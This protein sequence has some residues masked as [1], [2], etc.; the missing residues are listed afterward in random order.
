MKK[1]SL[2]LFSLFCVV[3]LTVNAQDDSTGVV[4]NSCETPY[5]CDGTAEL[6]NASWPADCADG[7]DEVFE[8]CCDNGF[9]AYVDA[10]L[11]GDSGDDSSDSTVV[12]DP[13]PCDGDLLTINMVDSYGDGGG[14]VT[15]GDVTAT[16]SGASSATEVCVDMSAC[17]VV[18]Y[19]ATDSWSYENSW[20]ISDA[21]G[22][23]LASGGAED[24][25]VGNCVSG[26][27]D[28]TAENYNAD[29]DI[30]DD[31]LCEYAL[32][33]G[34]MDETACNYDSAAEQD[35]GSCTYAAEGL[36][37]DG[38]CLSGDL[39]TMTDSWGDG[40]NG[41]VLTI[42]GVDYTIES[43]AS[44]TA[45]VDLTA[46][47]SVAWTAGS[48]DGETSWTLADLSGAGGSG[49]GVFGDCGVAGCTDAT[50]CNYNADASTDDGSCELPVPGFDCD[51]N[52]LSGDVVTINMFDSYGDGGGSVSVGGV[53]ATNAGV[54]SVTPA[55][56]DMSACNVVDYEATDSWSY[57]NSWSIT[58][59]LG[60]VLA[61]GLD[62]DGV[63]GTCESGCSDSTAVNFNADADLVDD[64]L[65][66]YPATC[67]YASSLSGSD[68]S[69]TGGNA[70]FSF[71]MAAA[72]SASITVDAVTDFPE[73]IE[74]TVY[75]DCE[76]SV[77]SADALDAGTYFVN[78]VQTVPEIG[79]VDF[80]ISVD[81]IILGCTDAGAANYNALA[82][83]DDESCT[84]IYGC[85]DVIAENYNP[86]ATND[87]GS[88][89][90]IP[91]CTDDEAINFNPA[92]T[93]EDGSCQYVQC[94]QTAALLTINSGSYGSEVSFAI[95]DLN[96][97]Y[98]A[99]I[100]Y[101]TLVSNTTYEIDLCLSDAN[102]Y[103]A[104][105]GDS[106]G[107][108]WN[109]GNFVITTCDGALVA[110]LGTIVPGE[111]EATIEFTVQDCD[112]YTFG[113]TDSLASN[114]DS[115]AD[116]EDGSCLY[117]GCTDS[118]YL[119]YDEGANDDDGSCLTL[120]VAGCTDSSAPN[121]DEAANVDDGSC[122]VPV[123]CADSL[124]DVVGFEISLA[125]SYGD[126]WNG[127][128]YSIV[129][130]SG[131]EVATGGMESGSEATYTH[132]VAPGCY[133]I[134]V[135]GGSW[136]T[137]TSWSIST[138]YNGASLVFGGGDN[139]VSTFSL[140]SDADCSEL[141]GCMDM[142]AENYSDMAVV[143]D[144]SCTYPTSESCEDA[145]AME[146]SASG[147][148]GQQ[149]WYSVSF[150]SVQFVTA[151][152][153][154]AISSFYS[155]LSLYASCGDT[156]L[157][158]GV[159]EAGTY[160]IYANSTYS[161]DFGEPF[162]LTVNSSDVVAGC[163]DIYAD[164]YNA[165]ANI[166]GEECLY[167]CEGTSATMI[168]DANTYGSEIYWE[169]IDSTGLIIAYA[170]EYVTGDVVEIPLC[171]EQNHN[172][173]MNAYD[174]Y[175]DGWNGST[176]S[177]SSE[178]GEDS[179]AFS[180]V[181]ANNG[182]E[183]PSNGVFDGSLADGYNLE[184]TE[185][186][187]LVSCDEVSP[188]CTD[189]TAFNYDSLANVTDGSCIP[190]IYG[191]TDETALNYDADAN[192]NVPEDCV[193]GCDGE[194]VTVNVTTGLYANEVSWQLLDADGAQLLTSD[195][196]APLANNTSYDHDIC[197]PIGA[198]FTF[199]AVDSYGDGWNG[200]SFNITSCPSVIEG[201]VSQASGQ[202][203]GTGADYVFT[204]TACSAIVPGCTN[205]N[206]LNYD[207][208]ATH[209]DGGC[210][211][212]V[213]SMLEPVDGAVV[214]L[215]S[216]DSLNPLTFTW[217]P[218][219]PA[220]LVGYGYYFIYF[221]T[222]S[223]DLE[224]SLA[225]S[226]SAATDSLNW[227]DEGALQDLYLDQGFGA[228]DEFTLYWWVSPDYYLYSDNE[229]S[230]FN[231]SNEI[232]LTIS[233]VFGCTDES[234][235]N[236]NEGATDDDGSCEYP[237]E[238]G[239]T[240]MMNDSYG[241]GWNGAELLINGF[242]YAL[243]SINDDGSYAQLCVDV[244]LESCITFDWIS[245]SYDYEIS[246]SLMNPSGE[247]VYEGGA[248]SVPDM[249]GS[250][251]MGCTDSNYAE[252]DPA[253]DIDDGS[254][255]TFLGS[256]NPLSLVMNDSYGDGWNG[257]TYSIVD[258]SGNEVANGGL[259]TGST[260]TDDLC[261]DDGCY[262]ITVGGGSWDSE[263]SWS[264]GEVASGVA[265]SVNFSL[266]GDCEFAV[267]GCT[268]PAA[269][270]YDPAATEDDGS[271]F[272]TVYGCT[273]PAADNYNEDANSDN[274]SCYYSCDE[275]QAQVDILVTTDT[276]SGSENTFTLYA[277]GSL[278]DY[279]DLSYDAQLTTL[280]NT[281][282]VDNGT[283]LEFILDDSYG[284]GIF[285]GGYEIYVCQES[286]T[287]FVAMTDV[288]SSSE[289]FM[290]VCG[291]ILGCMDESALN[292]DADAT[293][294]DGSCTYPCG[295]LDATVNL[296]TV[297]YGSEVSWVMY[298]GSDNV[299]ADGSGYANNSSYSVD[300]CLESGA[301]YD[302]IMLDSFGD[303]WNG[304]TIS[305]DAAC[306][307]LA[308]GELLSGDVGEVIFDADCGDVVEPGCPA[309]A[310]W[311]VTVTGANHTIF[312]PEGILP[313]MA[314][315]TELQHANVGV[316]FTN[317]N[318]DLVCAGSAEITPGEAVQI[319]AMG[320]D[321]TTPEVDGLAAGEAFVWMIADCNGN[322]F[323]GQATYSS[324]PEV[325]TTN[326][327][328]FVASISEVP[329]GP[330]SQM[331]ELPSGW[332]MFS[333]YM[334][335]DDMDMASVLSPII[336]KVIIAK[337]NSG[338]AYLVEW[339]FNGVGD[340]LVGQGYQ[341][342]TTEAVELE[343]SGAYA[344]PEDN[345]VD[346]TAGWNMVGYLR[347]DPAAADAV[348][349]DINAT[350]NLIIAKD[351][352][353][354]AYLPEWNFN[355]IG[356]MFP[357]QGYQLKTN[358]AD[359]LQYLSN[360]DSYRMSA[361]EVT[362]NNVSHYAKVAATDNNMTVVI[363]DAAWDILPTEGSEIA[364][365]DKDGNMVGS[366]IYSSPVTV[367]TVW[368]DDATTTSKDGML[369]SESVSFKVWNTN[370]VLDF[371]VEKWIEGSSS[372]Q[373][374]G[375]SVAST[376]ETNNVITELNASER[377]LVKVINVLGQEVNL[378]DEPF[379]GTVLFNVYDDGSVE[380]FVR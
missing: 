330:S 22:E 171:L 172:Y 69:N 59:T 337:N 124:G 98:L 351:Y 298:D 133:M 251:V 91:G 4:I 235:L 359:V 278:L 361:T 296:N 322:V 3:S 10:G 29:A 227:T 105:L 267:L 191:C 301:S 233:Q 116:Q 222:D 143:D 287:G 15:V 216:I 245:G 333:T 129:N 13:V 163:M 25:L 134:T 217:E 242:G 187:A 252:F 377:V 48:Y 348:M 82:T 277:D 62:A 346:I 76:G 31:S 113:C 345:P 80:T 170:D 56:V 365:F 30:A 192:T 79:D 352:N 92:A 57:E 127:N 112:T 200:G 46:C 254:C 68:S 8:Y 87:D 360:D 300:V 286:L 140:D 120:A 303:G 266:N 51:G 215:S 168:V 282:C 176:Y 84:Y 185:V 231:G 358:N 343:V 313:Q 324:G 328:T 304:A 145:I 293:A 54:S 138:E 273:D 378:D 319:A 203:A 94:L 224:G 184:S 17:N 122:Q 272:T 160:Y 201:G 336:D 110:A 40:W 12:V 228:G 327:L 14:Q 249:M 100:E 271:C 36:D 229:S 121:Y 292:Y 206:A 24:G 142:N 34:C 194:Y 197:L 26:C 118:D 141:T 295:G 52:C 47:T 43:G 37:C 173:T 323:A 326:A 108:G 71:E 307:Q 158:F 366:A 67:E 372:Y 72:G 350:G 58:D 85:T 281:Y 373:V 151:S 369:V 93:Q 257:A 354:A 284:D 107:D 55:C 270:N 33:Q 220:S 81:V 236:Y 331:L 178:C 196:D 132:C 9:P 308:Y 318:G 150:D 169:L 367:V 370:E 314:E 97:Q 380:Q 167:P 279:V 75:S 204:V 5:L 175:G 362:E 315:G 205:E 162:D 274:G 280:T 306:G 136:I 2:F 139:S 95:T 28:E 106:Y 275:G 156:A 209:D 202:P 89:E 207:S 221:S 159:L 340:L 137:E 332:S 241:D 259:L 316:F 210:E 125:D 268:D 152:L 32:V 344:F 135:S 128:V 325:Y 144:G 219:Y 117:P 355:G 226:A 39:L 234:A 35:N 248:G 190:F 74:T 195:L 174:S 38:N 45:C 147:Y 66:E 232:T 44:A 179:T 265:E 103:T 166:D 310:D 276:Y 23:I 109:G 96:N 165:D 223:S 83:V 177:I 111:S 240:L 41:A 86:D 119:E 375:I 131:E 155:E 164:N 349:A 225:I 290:A 73:F 11:C 212:Y 269:D 154:G 356:D 7:S 101:G 63:F 374:D 311:A 90:Y 50:A 99:E 188:G 262:T 157:S 88:C 180:Y 294:D 199:S 61:E 115:S 246:Y 297:D 213:P 247:V 317:D 255:S 363:E 347:T 19:E 186:F 211:F 78:V 21:S 243:N 291:D 1:I 312:I 288:Y 20:F 214:E 283:S 189:E 339:N 309:P 260:A 65:C 123:A 64:S 256:C 6:G 258:A 264:L 342:K 338:A 364:A 357:G 146:G 253:A 239:F 18:D 42:N 244:D 149:V 130:S 27:S 371:T 335:A 261:L 161:F 114:F 368:G 70:W 218:L 302:L 341:I 285:N 250:C 263:I 299:V 379:K 102:A 148:F 183:T 329:A 353:G 182:G 289:E 49:T 153:D 181:V 305:V 238:S 104:L 193:Y 208:E 230:Y 320:D 16:N 77:A 237:C 376:I 321:T 126:G 53:T 60:A 334:V 198:D